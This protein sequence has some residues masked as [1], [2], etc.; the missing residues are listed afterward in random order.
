[1]NSVY[2]KETQGSRGIRKV[3]GLML[4]LFFLPLA[5]LVFSSQQA[6]ASDIVLLVPAYGNPCCCTSTLSSIPP[7]VRG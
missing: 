6:T 1:M 3:A 2:Q 7:V 4:S 5:G